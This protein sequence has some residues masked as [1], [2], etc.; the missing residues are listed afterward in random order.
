M[1]RFKI[2]APIATAL[3]MLAVAAVALA[4]SQFKQTS[5][6]TLTATKAGKSTGF[7]AAIQSSDPGEPGSKPQALKTLTLTLP[8]ATKF[9]FKSKAIAMCTAS[10]IEIKGTGG[11]VCPAKSKI[12]AGT[13][14]ANGYPAIPL[15]PENATAYA[16]KGNIIFLLAPKGPAGA[17]LVLHGVVSANKV[18]TEVPQISFGGVSI[19]ITGL[20]LT[21]NKAGSGKAA[22]IT[23]GRC[24]SGKFKV[25]SSFLYYT[26]A[27][28]TL[29]SSSKCSK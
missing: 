29:S 21:V 1:R 4:S 16:G 9:N 13:A 20:K 22:F 27:R 3:T 8:S 26:G 28:E 10:D 6:V 17:P 15:I 2:A 19:V 14:E 7:K 24:A 12:G 23:A 18:T 5:N 25:K 11:A